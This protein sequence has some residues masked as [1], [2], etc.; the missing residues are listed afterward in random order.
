MKHKVT[1]LYVHT[2]GNLIDDFPCDV[3]EDGS[4]QTNGSIECIYQL[5]GKKYSVI[6]DWDT[7]PRFPSEPAHEIIEEE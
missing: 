3:G 6:C 7:N 5:E 1:N 4:I 2:N